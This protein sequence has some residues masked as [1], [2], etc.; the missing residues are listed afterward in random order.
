MEN[1]PF[2]TLL[3]SPASPP[4]PQPTEAHSSAV[5]PNTAVVLVAIACALVC[6]IGLNSTL[7]CVLRC[8]WRT[9][10]EPAGWIAARR[11]N[12]GM[13][14]EAVLALPIA[15][16]AVPPTSSAGDSSTSAV[17]AGTAV[18]CPICLSDLTDGEKVRVLPECRHRFHVGC[19]DTWL[20]SHSSCPTCR[21]R[22]SSTPPPLPEIV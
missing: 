12:A 22:I 11:F 16:Y 7:K 20:L 17:A 6:A 1:Q 3:T 4:T 8:T 10:T 21:W 2:N 14:R 18:G 19:I 15:I 9:I 13:R 5:S